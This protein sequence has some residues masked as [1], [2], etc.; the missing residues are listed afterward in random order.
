M[1]TRPAFHCRSSLIP[2]ETFQLTGP[3]V[4]H[5]RALR[6]A[7]GSE[8]ELLDGVGGTAICRVAA[9]AKKFIELD[10]ISTAF[11][12]KAASRAIL[13]LA[14]SKTT[15]RGF[16]M[17][18]AAELGCARVWLWEAA[19]SIGR[20]SEASLSACRGQLIAGATQSHNPWFPELRNVVNLNGLLE[21]AAAAQIQNRILP[22]EDQARSAMLAPDLLGQPGL[23]L[24]VIGPEGGFAEE[25]VER[26]RHNDFIVVSL[27]R[28]VLRCETA[29]SL[30]L[31]LHAWAAQ[32]PGAP[33]AN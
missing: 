8:I 9:F 13:A 17:E 30:C 2:G 10:V 22:W 5:A 21:A 25:E 15:R 18:K 3:E 14:M 4:S 12:P 7:P 16:V 32:L 31:G 6:I 33:D 19:R 20:I 11:T 28:Q 27:G 24:F 1:N 23:T 29:A 26:M